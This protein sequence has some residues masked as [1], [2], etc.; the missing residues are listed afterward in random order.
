MSSPYSRFE[1]FL[2][3]HILVPASAPA[4]FSCLDHHSATVSSCSNIL[5]CPFPCVCLF[6]LGLRWPPAWFITLL[7]K[8]ATGISIVL[9]PSAALTC[10]CSDPNGDSGTA[11]S[12]GPPNSPQNPVTATADGGNVNGAPQDQSCLVQSVSTVFVTVF[13][14]N[15]ASTGVDSVLG[16]T[17]PDGTVYRTVHQS[18]TV[19]VSPFTSA[20]D[21]G[22]TVAAFTTLTI[23]D[24]WGTSLPS[25]VNPLSSAS[26]LASSAVTG[27]PFP[28]SVPSALPSY[29]DI[30]NQNTGDAGG[31]S[32]SSPNLVLTPPVPSS[33]ALSGYPQGTINSNADGT[34]VAVTDTVIEWVTNSGGPSP[35]TVLSVH[36]IDIGSQANS[37][38]APSTTCW[39]FTGTDGRETVV[40]SPV[41]T[42][43]GAQGGG[44]PAS[45]VAGLDT[46]VQVPEATPAIQGQTPVTTITASALTP[47]YP[48]AGVITSA[49]V[50]VVGP[51]GVTSVLQSSW[52]VQSA[53]VTDT[54]AAL[55]S[56]NAFP[57]GGNQ[58]SPQGG[59]VTS[60]TTFTI[61]GPNGQPTVVE[62][63]LVIPSSAILVTDLPQNLPNGITILNT[64]QSPTIL[65]AG[66]S[67][68]GAVATCTSYTLLGTDGRLTVVESTFLVP[69]PSG[70]QETATTPLG[71]ITGLPDQV[72]GG[73]AQSL[74]SA[75]APPA[76]TTAISYTVVGSDGLPTV[77]ASTAVVPNNNFPPAV[78][79]SGLPSLVPS[80]PTSLPQGTQP[81]PQ[82]EGYTTCI[83]VDIVG[84][85]GVTTSVV[86][87][88]VLTPPQASQS[89]G[90]TMPVTTVGFPSLVPQ[91]LPDLPAG[92]TSSVA[93]ANPITTAVTVEM[94]GSNGAPSS[95]VQTIVITPLDVQGPTSSVSWIV[96]A[97]GV[98][99]S[100][101]GTPPNVP[102]SWLQI[103]T[104]ST[105]S[106]S[107]FAPVS[108]GATA[109]PSG[110]SV[111]TGLGA[112]SALSV[113]SAVP[114]ISNYGSL[115]DQGVSAIEP[116][117]QPSPGGYGWQPADAL[118]AAYGVM[119][120]SSRSAIAASPQVH[121]SVWVN[122]IPEPTTTYTMNFPLT[123]LA[124][125]PVP[126][127]APR[128]KRAIRRQ[129]R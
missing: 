95:F 81:S 12:S 46:S 105:A 55:P 63:T 90:A 14:N 38:A 85:G 96:I 20:N 31:G 114:T 17:G 54:S 25:A 58:G 129:N 10:Q 8:L 56:G 118:P 68:P 50:T 28:Q 87:T 123:T 92:I 88:I 126:I 103:V 53:I 91:S 121:T 19:E 104:P 73:P 16:A 102:S 76:I 94:T 70:V 101:V 112:N 51:D 84:P 45:T 9:A 97:P 22:A 15:P 128:A 82:G 75:V 41:G 40:E 99:V 80:Q 49:A 35:I 62:S 34:Y 93:A 100:G 67:V 69:A 30:G 42:I 86:E 39:T 117:T 4:Q 33:A 36:T 74:P 24:L 29:S 7:L 65:S 2:S 125:V 77:I 11:V 109:G 1:S 113:V 78:T 60:C 89:F 47:I 64:P 120:S 107:G 110:P 115:G 37:A 116:A 26:G 83:T 122:I 66:S 106:G 119:A 32:T 79:A 52:A 23:P 27:G 3:P 5:S 127:R 108:T 98:T 111:V 43:H 72:S 48:G 71:I 61:I 21:D 124:T 59:G 13:P 57:P 44:S 6:R 18:Q